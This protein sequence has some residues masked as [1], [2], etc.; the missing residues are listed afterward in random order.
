M[1]SVLQEI[2]ES[3]RSEVEKRE[4]SISLEDLETRNTSVRDFENKLRGDGVSII[5]EIKRK[6]PSQGIIRDDIDPVQMAKI[7]EANGASA[8][9]VLTDEPYFGGNLDLLQE[10][11]ASVELPILRKDFIVTEYQVH[12]SYHAGTDAILLIAEALTTPKLSTLYSLARSLGLHVLVEGY[13]NDSIR[14]INELNPEI[15]GINARNLDNMQVDFD[16]ILAKRELLPGDAITV[17]ESGVQTPDQMTRIREAG[18][19]AALIGTSLMKAEDPGALLQSLITE[20]DSSE[21]LRDSV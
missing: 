13:T 1:S 17:A 18:Y 21:V 20:S 4:K 10:I 15:I 9:S 5:A 12:E 8:I 16:G 7:Y 11:R 14:I 3:T 19:D 2:V 6:S